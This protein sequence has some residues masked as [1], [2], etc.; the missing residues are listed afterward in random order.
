MND[1]SVPPAMNSTPTGPDAAQHRASKPTYMTVGDGPMSESAKHLTELLD[2]D[3]GYGTRSSD[4][5]SLAW[6]PSSMTDQFTST[7]SA[8]GTQCM[9][10]IH[11]GHSK[12]TDIAS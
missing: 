3:S 5:D 10:G 9:S 2:N 12:L 1:E 8:E 7:R 11:S 4:V 6:D